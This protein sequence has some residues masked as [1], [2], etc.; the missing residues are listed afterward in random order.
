[1][2]FRSLP[3]EVFNRGLAFL[4]L[5]TS[6]PLMASIAALIWLDD[7]FPVLF[8]QPRAGKDGAPFTILK[9]RSLEAT[10]GE[11]T[12]PSKHTTRIGSH[13]RRWALDELPQLWNVVRGDMN[14]VGPRPVL[15]S[16]VRGYDK[17]ARRR[18]DVRPGLTGWAQVHG[19]NSLDW[20][21]RLE[22]DLWYVRHRSLSLD[23]WILA[24]TPLV[25][26]SGNGVYGA[27][28]EDPSSSEVEI[29]LS[30]QDA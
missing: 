26:L 30:S 21:K 19:R 15:L 3:R 10:V 18:L 20:T 5:A 2:S 8:T 6:T 1:M 13:L 28:T 14:L 17:R 4:F 7:G 24:K 25:L 23:L 22:H 27:G 29:H 9:F 11:T 16:E 12:S